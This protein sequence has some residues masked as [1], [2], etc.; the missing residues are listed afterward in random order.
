MKKYIAK[1]KLKPCVTI[2]IG[3]DSPIVKSKEKIMEK[4]YAETAR[5]IIDMAE[6]MTHSQWNKINHLIEVSFQG[7]EAKLTFEK[8]KELDL[9]MKQNFI[10]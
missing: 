10:L 1:R 8:P 9:L 2:A 3:K 5:A 6:G 7:Q 4:C